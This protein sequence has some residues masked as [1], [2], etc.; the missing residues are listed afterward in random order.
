MKEGN[1]Q[2][3]NGIALGDLL[4]FRR[5]ALSGRFVLG[6]ATT[7]TVAAAT[8]VAAVAA[9][10]AAAAAAGGKRNARHFFVNC[11]KGSRGQVFEKVIALLL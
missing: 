9:A 7:A 10:A 6:C 1:A 11:D 5:I 3:D 8:A 2:L 4:Q